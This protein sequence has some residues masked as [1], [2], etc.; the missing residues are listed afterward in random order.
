MFI[1]AAVGLLESAEQLKPM[2]L[3]LCVITAAT[4]VLV[5]G[6][7]GKVSDFLIGRGKKK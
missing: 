7:T 6:V 2:L 5:M 4:T 3:P 1:P